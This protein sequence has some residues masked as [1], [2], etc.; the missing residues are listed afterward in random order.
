MILAGLCLATSAGAMAGPGDHA[1]HNE[2]SRQTPQAHKDVRHDTRHMVPTH[3][4]GHG[5]RIQ[6]PAARRSE[7]HV[8]QHRWQRGDRIPASYRSS[9][10]VVRNWHSH[11]LRR[12]ARGHEWVSVGRDYLLI[13]TATGLIA[14]AVLGR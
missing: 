12:P 9:R 10:H 5:P 8:R 2:H 3:A 7:H 11:G 4:R 1:R 13:A 6:H 14:Q